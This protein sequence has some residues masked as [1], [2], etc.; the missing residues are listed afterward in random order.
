V[1]H[2]GLGLVGVEFGH[3]VTQILAILFAPIAKDESFVDQSILAVMRIY[4]LRRAE[5][6]DAFKFTRLNEPL[7]QDTLAGAT[8]CTDERI[9]PFSQ[10]DTD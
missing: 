9:Y 2:L 5:A 8:F 3:L 6:D 1:F 4:F 7:G 10:L